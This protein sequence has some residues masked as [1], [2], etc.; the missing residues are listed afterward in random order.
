MGAQLLVAL[1]FSFQFDALALVMGL[2]EK[3]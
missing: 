2:E 3:V 1:L